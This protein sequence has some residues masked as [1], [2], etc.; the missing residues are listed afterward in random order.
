MVLSS[1][2]FLRQV[3]QLAL[4]LDFGDSLNSARA[5]RKP[6]GSAVLTF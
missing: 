1:A 4:G 5:T 6:P 3:Q 2:E